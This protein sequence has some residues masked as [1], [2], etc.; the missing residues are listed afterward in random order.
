MHLAGVHGQFGGIQSNL[1]WE[2]LAE[3]AD[4]QDGLVGVRGRAGRATGSVD[5]QLTPHSFL[6]PLW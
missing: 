2:A 4:N 3:R 1:P 5:T 6:K